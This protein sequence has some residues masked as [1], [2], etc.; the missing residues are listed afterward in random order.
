M[1]AKIAD[2]KARLGTEDEAVLKVE[3]EKDA[4]WNSLYSR[5]EDLNKALE[6]ERR[7]AMAIVRQ[8]LIADEQKE[9]A[10]Q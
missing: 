4:E 10:A 8:R 5:V 6:D 1:Q 3:L 9:P 2:A 7:R